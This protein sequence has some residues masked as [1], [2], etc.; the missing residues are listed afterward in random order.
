ML[1][2]LAGIP[3]QARAQPAQVFRSKR[4]SL[5]N[6]NWPRTYRLFREE[7]A[8][9]GIASILTPSGYRYYVDLGPR[10]LHH[11]AWTLMLMFYVGTVARYRPVAAR[12]VME[13]ELRPVISEAVAVCPRQFLYQLTSMITKRICSVPHASLV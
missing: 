5:N 3:F 11:L 13:G 8:R 7:I 10:N 1:R 6:D 12:E 4:R 9:L 2:S